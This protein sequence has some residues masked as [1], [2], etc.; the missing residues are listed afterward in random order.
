MTSTF[1]INLKSNFSEFSKLTDFL[2][3]LGK[4][5]LID[6]NLIFQINLSLEEIFNNIVIYGYLNNDQKEIRFSFKLRRKKLIINIEDDAPEF[7]PLK[8]PKPDTT[9]SLKDTNAGGLGIHFFM[10]LM[11][12]ISYERKK[13]K[14]ILKI[15]KKL[16]NDLE[17]GA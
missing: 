8:F 3:K 12:E 13:N 4:K 7:N 11:D 5:H 16:K 9:K 17:T 15:I 1:N 10:S 6:S 2:N 14:N